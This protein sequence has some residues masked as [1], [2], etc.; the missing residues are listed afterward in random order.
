MG[1]TGDS[2]PEIQAKIQAAVQTC[3]TDF[4]RLRKTDPSRAYLNLGI[5]VH[6]LTD[7]WTPSHATRN[8]Q[9]GIELFQDYNEQSLHYHERNDN[10]IENVPRSYAD[11]VKQSAQLIQMATGSGPIDAS[12]L[13]TLATG[14]VIGNVPGTKPVTLKG[15][16]RNGIPG[17]GK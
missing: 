10:L 8:A 9:G 3:L 16:L 13:F 7:T 2:A 15:A 12:S 4:R 11:A 5:A 6:I 1:K 17:G 14:S